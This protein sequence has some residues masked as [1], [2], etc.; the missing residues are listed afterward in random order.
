MNKIEIRN[1]VIPLGYETKVFFIDE[2]PLYEYICEWLS[3]KSELL[4]S[5]SPFCELAICWTDDY[6]CEGDSQFMRFI[7]NQD[8]AITPIL[9]C[10]DDFDFS[11]IL[12]VADIVR[13]NHK[14]IWK[15]IGQVNHA[16]ESFEEEKRSGILHENSHALSDPESSQFQKWVSEH[17]TKEL[18]LRR[19]NY[20]YL[21]YQ[22][23]NNIDW[24]VTC[25]FEFD[26]KEYD[27]VVACCYNR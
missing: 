22:N 13:Q 12:I 26:E 17:W 21:Y 9:S 20:T 18:Y 10:P 4:Q 11:C 5:V 1:H 15:R 24:F 16:G 6:D 25:N 8:N 27:A 14:V 7:L 3:E 2:R 23:E 19:I